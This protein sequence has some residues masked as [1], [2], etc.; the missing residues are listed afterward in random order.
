[1]TRGIGMSSVA[2]S[3]DLLRVGLIPYLHYDCGVFSQNI[4]FSQLRYRVLREQ[5][6]AKILSN[7][8]NIPL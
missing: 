2:C 8:Q 3:L 1:V 6:A 7:R 4:M 5:Q